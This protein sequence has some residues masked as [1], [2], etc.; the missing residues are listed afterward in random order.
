M[1]IVIDN[2]L[3]L[4]RAISANAKDLYLNLLNFA[5]DSVT[6]YPTHDYIAE[7]L[8]VSSRTVIRYM[9]ELYNYGLIKV[10]REDKRL[11]ANNNYIIVPVEWVDFETTY[12]EKDYILTKPQFEELKIKILDFYESEGEATINEDKP[13]A[14]KEK[15]PRVIKTIDIRY[16]EVM[17]KVKKKPEYRYNASDCCVIFAKYLQDVK[18][19][20]CSVSNAMNNAIMKKAL[21]GAENSDIEL[22]I[23]TFIDMYDTNFKK[24]KF[25]NPEIRQLG[26]DWILNRVVTAVAQKKKYEQTITKTDICYD[27][28]Y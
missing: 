6:C 23:K 16:E 20:Q 22:T 9:Q 13:K 25:P 11:K 1:K 2:K 19:L 10:Y 3:I 15:K 8:N 27:V 17:A 28:A 18:G 5:M 7:K 14:K 24:D 12:S 21:V 26:Q 4:T